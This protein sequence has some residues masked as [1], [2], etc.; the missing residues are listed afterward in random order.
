MAKNQDQ[1]SLENDLLDFINRRFLDTIL[2]NGKKPSIREIA[3][4]TNIG[5][6]TIDKILKK[7]G[8]DLPIS[9]INKICTYANISLSKFFEDFE[10][11][12]KR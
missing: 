9:T 2:I 4:K 6:S 7:E 1:K 3:K 11:S 5:R 10:E 12:L 8:Y